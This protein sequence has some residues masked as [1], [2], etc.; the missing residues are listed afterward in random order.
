MRPNTRAK[1]KQLPSTMENVTCPLCDSNV[2][3]GEDGVLCEGSCSTWFHA[4]CMG[5]FP[6]HF[7]SIANKD[8]ISN[9]GSVHIVTL[10]QNS[11]QPQTWE[12]FLLYRMN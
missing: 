4:G 3:D 8:K 9:L 6:D 2:T 7:P 1:A 5:M 10:I 12:M 11:N